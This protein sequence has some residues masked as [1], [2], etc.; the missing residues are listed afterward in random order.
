M[1][2]RT[3]FVVWALN[4]GMRRGEIL[5]LKWEQIRNGFIYLTK[6]KTSEPRQIPINDTLEALFR[7]IRK[8]SGL[9]SKY[10]F[11]YDG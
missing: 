1:P 7:Q 5:G 6:T 8:E 10:V 9:K 2:A 11:L 3:T 4:T